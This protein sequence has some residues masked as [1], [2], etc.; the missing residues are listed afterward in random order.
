[1]NEA[2]LTRSPVVNFTMQEKGG[3][4]KTPFTINQAAFAQS[5]GVKHEVV[6]CDVR[7]T[8]ITETFPEALVLSVD[9]RALEAGDSE[10]AILLERL[11]RQRQNLIVDTGANTRR[12]FNLFF[13]TVRFGDLV[14]AGEFRCNIF[15]PVE[16]ADW[17]GRDTHFFFR[18][19]K[20]ECPWAALYQV[21]IKPSLDY[22][23]SEYPEHPDELTI[24][25]PFIPL[26]IRKQ[27]T[28]AN[29]TLQQAMEGRLKLDII[30]REL[31]GS[32]MRDLYSQ[33]ERRVEH[34]F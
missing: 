18:K 4:W 21:R 14:R 10:L 5:K 30:Q 23:P 24:V 25:F 7:P 32:Y 26:G 31:V 27:L 20:E 3:K 15:C 22:A 1:M 11:T 33:F 28:A 9:E 17:S 8:M 34:I 13:E 29:C 19:L 12:C 16:R 6:D 2:T